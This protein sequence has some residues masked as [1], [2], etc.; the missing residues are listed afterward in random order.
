MWGDETASG[1]WD[2]CFSEI[3]ED[4]GWRNVEG[5][6]YL[7]RFVRDATHDALMITIV[8]DYLISESD[9]YEIGDATH[10]AIKAKLKDVKFERAPDSFAGFAIA[11]SSSTG[12]LTISMR[13]KIKEA[14]RTHFPDLLDTDTAPASVTTEPR[15]KSLKSI[16]DEMK[17]ATLK[18]HPKTGRPILNARQKAVQRAIGGMQFPLRV[19]PA[20]SLPM[21]L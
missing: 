11:H 2:T 21:Y 14:V 12:A 4:I 17:L 7:K 20:I 15:I 6:P 9:G 18:P 19:N 16:A 1:V 10:A 5:V 3:C 8:D 13:Q